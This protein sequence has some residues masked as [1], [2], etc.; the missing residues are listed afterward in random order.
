M[1]GEGGNAFSV[2]THTRLRRR[3]RCSNTKLSASREQLMYPPKRCK[4]LVRKSGWEVELTGQ[5]SRGTKLMAVLSDPH[6]CG[7]SR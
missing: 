3:R 7:R 5:T 1:D 6:R 2:N 4:P